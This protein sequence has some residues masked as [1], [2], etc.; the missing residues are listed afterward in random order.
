MVGAAVWEGYGSG[1]DVPAEP[2]A[3][4]RAGSSGAAQAAHAVVPGRSAA[5]S[6][7]RDA[8]T[9]ARPPPGSGQAAEDD[10]H[11]LIRAVGL[12]GWCANSPSTA[13]SSI[14]PGAM[15]LRLS[16]A[17]RHLLQL[18]RGISEKLQAE[19]SDH[20][21]APLRVSI[22]VGDIEGVTPA[23]RDQAERAV[24]HAAAVAS[25]EKDPFVRELIERFDATLLEESVKPL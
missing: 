23:Q 22:E 18:N 25:L 9:P 11:G 21:G 8:D 5:V 20:F 24:R 14:G 3:D 7:D 6:P 13:S 1:S 2:D 4:R 12:G 10:W 17:H 16:S 15:V 19:L